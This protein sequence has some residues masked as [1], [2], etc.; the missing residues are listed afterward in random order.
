MASD[1]VPQCVLRT[2]LTPFSEDSVCH[3]VVASPSTGDTP[4]GEDFSPFQVVL[5]PLPTSS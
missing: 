3:A 1:S 5:V 4:L 2:R